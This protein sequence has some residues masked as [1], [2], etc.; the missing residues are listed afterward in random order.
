LRAIESYEAATLEDT[1]DDR[2]PEI[3]VVQHAM[4]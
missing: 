2:L 1:I 3:L 4:H